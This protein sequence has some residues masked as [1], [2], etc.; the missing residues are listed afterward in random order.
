[1]ATTQWFPPDAETMPDH[2]GKGDG[3]FFEVAVHG[4]I[5]QPASP[6]S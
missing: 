4:V 2:V 6:W 1:M 5:T 3:A